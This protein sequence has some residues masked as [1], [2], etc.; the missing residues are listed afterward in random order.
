MKRVIICLIFSLIMVTGCKSSGNKK[1]AAKPAVDKLTEARAKDKEWR[2]YLAV[3]QKNVDENGCEESK[4]KLDTRFEAFNPYSGNFEF[5]K[6]AVTKKH[7]IE[8]YEYI[9]I[10]TRDGIELDARFIP[11]ENA[12][13]TVIVLHGWSSDMDFGLM[14]SKFLLNLGYQIIVY[15]ARF[16]NYHDRPKDYQGF[17]GNDIDDIG[18]VIKYAKSRN[19]VDS[20]KLGLLGFSY[21]AAKSVIAGAKY[22]DLKFVMAD[23]APVSEM[24][25]TKEEIAEMRNNFVKWQGERWLTENITSLQAVSKISPIPLLLL[26]GEKDTAVPLSHSEE[27]FKNAKEPKEFHTFPNSGHCLAMMTGDKDAYFKAVD[28]FLAKHLK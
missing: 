14:Q 23:A 17:I 20:N 1:E 5:I 27:L 16:W 8:K 4:F 21:G 12:K 22:R 7:R 2:E 13:G 6:D 26:H 25:M 28:D 18:D 19:D 11:V 3:L 15:N 9:K 24:W 10:P